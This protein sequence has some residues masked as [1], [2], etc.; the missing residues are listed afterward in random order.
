MQYEV[1]DKKGPDVKTKIRKQVGI[2]SVS[3]RF[4]NST[5]GCT[6]SDEM[7]P[8]SV[9]V[10]ME[11]LEKQTRSTWGDLSRYRAGWPCFNSNK[12]FYLTF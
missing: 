4:H 7:F 11:N 6:S 2:R 5:N 10:N 3:T 12:N 9:V 8:A 1:V